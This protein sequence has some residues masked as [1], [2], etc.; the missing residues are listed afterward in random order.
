MVRNP[1]EWAEGLENIDCIPLQTSTPSS[2]NDTLDI[3]LD[4]GVRIQF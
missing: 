4:L 3:K 2:K 1:V